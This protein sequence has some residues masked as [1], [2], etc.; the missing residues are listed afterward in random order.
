MTLRAARNLG[1]TVLLVIAVAWSAA[2]ARDNAATE[3]LGLL[4]A[5]RVEAAAD[6]LNSVPED[7]PHRP[8]AEASLQFHLGRYEPAAARIAEV[9]AGDAE[10]EELRAR[11]AG[12][13]TATRGMV[14]RREGRFLFRHQP[15]PDAILVPLAHE[16]MEKQLSI[17]EERLGEEVPGPVVVEFFPTVATFVEATGLPRAWVETTNTVA[18]AKWDRVLVLSPMNLPWGYPWVDT[19]AHELVHHVLSRASANRAPIWFQEGTARSWEGA[20][21]GAGPGAWMDPRSETLLAA[22]RTGG[23]LIPFARIHP[24]MAALPSAADA[25]L[26]FAEVA[27]AVELVQT[28][29]GA[30]G[31]QD[32]VAE[33]AGGADLME[34]LSRRLGGSGEFEAMFHDH[35]RSLS[36]E[37]RADITDLE[38][39]LATGAAAPPAEG[40]PPWDPALAQDKRVADLVR[41]G[42]LLRGRGHTSAA[43]IE[44]EKAHR[45]ERFHAPSLA[46]RRASAFEAMGRVPEAISALQESVGHYPEFTPNVSALARLLADRGAAREAARWALAALHLNPFDPMP[47]AVLL[48][49][50]PP[51]GAEAARE[52]EALRL[53][54][55]HLGGTER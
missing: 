55:E 46:L 21:R 14:E 53:L 44:F 31:L 7:D 43:L 6:R 24:S 51:Q 32:L 36:L 25:A 50:L 52:T 49:N 15:G 18:I 42:D 30:R 5:T 3:V 22:A 10:V 9:A 4:D 38:P 23:T 40:S 8:L 39:K 12:A 11:I 27:V 35:L 33:L 29:L 28:R 45:I 19:L 1:A 47:H 37:P 26:A 20:W 54:G 41:I 2:G 16:P 17:L 34:E 48:R 13:R